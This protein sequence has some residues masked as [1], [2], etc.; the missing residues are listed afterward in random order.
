[1]E[2]YAAPSLVANSGDMSTL[3][4]PERPFSPKILFECFDPQ[5]MFLSTMAKGSTVFCGHIFILGNRISEPY[6]M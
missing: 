2:P 4:I 1:M 5:I 6:S 3:I